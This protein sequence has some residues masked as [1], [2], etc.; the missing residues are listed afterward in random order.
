MQ[1]SIE[2]NNYAER[3]GDLIPKKAS[4]T[5]AYFSLTT[6]IIAAG[7]IYLSQQRATQLIHD[8]DTDFR[9]SATNRSTTSSFV[10]WNGLPI[11]LLVIAVAA[12][13]M[14]ILSRDQRIGRLLSFISLAATVIALMVLGWEMYAPL[15][16]LV[17]KLR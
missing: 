2:S 4:A 5:L 8:I 11:L 1:N 14:G 17:T 3:P 12:F 15:S 9:N 6:A 10:F 16:D 13:L 7:F